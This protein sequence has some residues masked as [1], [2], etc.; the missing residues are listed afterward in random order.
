MH[1]CICDK[2]PDDK[3]VD[4][5]VLSKDKKKLI[6]KAIYHKDCPEH[7]IKLK[8]DNKTGNNLVCS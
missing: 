8:D 2:V 1:D 5:Q 7:G 4:I 6:I 3:R